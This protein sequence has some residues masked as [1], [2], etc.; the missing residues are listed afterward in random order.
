MALERPPAPKWGNPEDLKR[1]R[2]SNDIAIKYHTVIDKMQGFLWLSQNYGV[3][4]NQIIGLNFPGAIENGRVIPEVVNWY[5]HHHLEFN[6]PETFDR[7]NRIFKGGEKIAIPAKLLNIEDPIEIVAPSKKTNIWVGAG[8]KIGMTFV[9]SGNETSKIG[10]V[11]LD[12]PS[13]TFSA[14]STGTRLG[15]GFGASGSPMIVVVTSMKDPRELNGLMGAGWGYNVALGPKLS[16]ILKAG[17][18]KPLLISLEKYAETLKNG[19]KVGKSISKLA[20]YN[21][22]I[23]DIVKMAGMDTEASEPQI[24]VIESPL[25]GFGAEVSIVHT[26]TTWHFVS[27]D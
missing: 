25:G 10:C 20:E 12:D 24:L 18:F 15:P 3:A 9:A 27:F 14:T 1:F 7:Q 26:V 19:G 16:S 23:V 22:Q 21:S 6:C 17:K 13:I 5:L 4:A 8:Y 2:P 11:S